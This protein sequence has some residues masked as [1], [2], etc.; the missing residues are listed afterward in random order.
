[1]K[2]SRIL[3][4]EAPSTTDNPTDE[5]DEP[6]ESIVDLD[7]DDDD[8]D[9]EETYAVEDL[10][11][12]EEETESEETEPSHSELD[13]TPSPEPHYGLSS[14][15]KHVALDASDSEDSFEGSL[16]KSQLKL[17]MSPLYRIYYVFYL[18]CLLRVLSIVELNFLEDESDNEDAGAFA[19]G[20]GALEA[21][22]ED[23][24]DDDSV[25][26]LVQDADYIPGATSE[27][28]IVEPIPVFLWRKVISQFYIFL[29]KSLC[30]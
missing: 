15:H 25:D 27:Q 18:L 11:A 9:E 26:M 17:G 28:A 21:E 8:D 23:E 20:I 5:G 12:E 24:D 22:A 2:R 4:L 13:N 10:E 30:V 7:A 1:M 19:S 14:L 29:R 16:E 3:D 6:F